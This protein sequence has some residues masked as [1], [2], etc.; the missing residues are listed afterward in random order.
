MA[1]TDL[2]NDII[3]I[4]DEFSALMKKKG[5]IIRSRSYQ[6]ASNSLSGSKHPITEVEQFK[7][8]KHIGDAMYKKIVE[9]LNSGEISSLSRLRETIQTIPT[10]LFSNIYG[11][12]PVKE[13]QLLT[14]NVNTI[15]ELRDRQDELLNNVQKIGLKYYEDILEKIPRTE[16]DEYKNIF[17]TSFKTV[18]KNNI[19]QF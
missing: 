12:G 1:S 15:R 2:R 5:D 10:P 14:S 9:Y 3:P 19:D 16:I 11:I 13:K 18:K 8:V 4:L 6:K 7:S 17:D